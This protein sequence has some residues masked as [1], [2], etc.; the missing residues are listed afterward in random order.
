[1]TISI[2]SFPYAYFEEHLKK[3]YGFWKQ[4]QCYLLFSFK[5]IFFRFTIC[6]NICGFYKVNVLFQSLR[7]SRKTKVKTK[8]YQNRH[9]PRSSHPELFL[10]KDVL[11]ICG[12][13]TGEHSLTPFLKNTSLRLLLFFSVITNA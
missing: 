2:V 1:M 10:E 11:K 9:F 6:F 12:K 3:I 8:Q 7:I 13:F 4:R 5:V